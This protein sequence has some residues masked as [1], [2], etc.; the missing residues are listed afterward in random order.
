MV[1]A[2]QAAPKAILCRRTEL[3]VPVDTDPD[4]VMADL[5]HWTEIGAP[6]TNAETV[7]WLIEVICWGRFSCLSR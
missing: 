3:P 4:N 2:N 6:A 1:S 7:N 5:P